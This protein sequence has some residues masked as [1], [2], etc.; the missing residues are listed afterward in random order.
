MFIGSVVSLWA[1]TSFGRRTLLLVG[2]L[3]CAIFLFL[4][5]I[6]VVW[7]LDRMKLFMICAYSFTFNV[8][9]ATVINVYLVEICTDIAFGSALVIMQLI[10]LIQTATALQMIN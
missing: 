5:A 7:D 10:I 9:N 4:L 8:T 6:A 2:H 1:V 3:G